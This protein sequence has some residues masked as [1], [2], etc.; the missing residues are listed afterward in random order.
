MCASGHA[1]LVFQAGPH[2]SLRF[3]DGWTYTF[4]IAPRLRAS[5]KD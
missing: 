3:F 2:S 4:K 5:L 1:L